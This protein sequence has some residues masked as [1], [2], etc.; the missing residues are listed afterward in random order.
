MS[1]PRLS[2]EIEAE[3]MRLYKTLSSEEVARR[4]FVHPCTVRVVVRR[5][6]GR[7]RKRG[8]S[9]YNRLS[10]ED[11]QRTIDLYAE[12]FTLQQVAVMEGVTEK[13]IMWRLNYCGVRRRS[14]KEA[15]AEQRRLRAEGRIQ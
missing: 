8:G 6:G 14:Y 4:T 7:I 10:Q 11:Y 5:N 15:M 3:I 12:G 9:R 1:A 13:A 2:P